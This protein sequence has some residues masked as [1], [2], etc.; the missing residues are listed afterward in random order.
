MVNFKALSFALG[1]LLLLGL[2]SPLQGS[3]GKAK[4]GAA[5]DAPA[6]RARARAVVGGQPKAAN[7]PP[8]GMALADDAPDD[9]EPAAAAADLPLP[10]E[11][12]AAKDMLKDAR[13]DSNALYHA[14]AAYY[15]AFNGRDNKD[16]AT[17][18]GYYK[19][20]LL[21][22]LLV[23]ESCLLEIEAN[24]DDPKLRIA[25]AAKTLA[26]N[27]RIKAQKLICRD[28]NRLAVTMDDALDYW[29]RAQ[30][31]AGVKA[32]SDLK[33]AVAHV[34]ERMNNLGVTD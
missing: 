13:D 2:P 25:D 1:L 17:R 19:V 8:G 4:G 9:E 18:I 34:A 27:Y 14:L 24:L 21:H 32:V 7:P 26:G 11:K 33:Q 12:K 30:D 15:A 20:L 16:V 29:N 10:H 31:Q 28:S 3:D 6:A 22:M 5:P 23:R